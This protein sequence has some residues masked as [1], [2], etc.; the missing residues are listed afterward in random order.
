MALQCSLCIV[1]L[2]VI[3]P[4]GHLRSHESA[5]GVCE[6]LEL[7][8]PRPEKQSIDVARSS[9]VGRNN[10][11][12]ISPEHHSKVSHETI[13]KAFVNSSIADSTAYTSMRYVSDLD[14]DDSARTDLDEGKARRAAHT[15]DGDI[16]LV[17][18]YADT[19]DKDY[20]AARN[21]ECAK[22]EK[23]HPHICGK[24][25]QWSA[26]VDYGSLRLSLRSVLRYAKSF[27][28]NIYIITNGDHIPWLREASESGPIHVVNGNDLIAKA[29]GHVPNFNSHAF[30]LVMHRIPGLTE[31]FLQADDDVLFWKGAKKSSWFTEKG[32]IHHLAGTRWGEVYDL[33]VER[34]L[35][36]D[37]NVH[38][39]LCWS[40]HTF[41]PFRKKDMEKMW[42]QFNPQL[43]KTL[44]H[45]FRHPDDIDV[46]SFYPWFT[47]AQDAKANQ[48]KSNKYACGVALDCK[49][50]SGHDLGENYMSV[51]LQTPPGGCKDSDPLRSLRET[52]F[53]EPLPWEV[54]TAS[55]EHHVSPSNGTH[56]PVQLAHPKEAVVATAA[57]ATVP[58][59]SD[60]LNEVA[61]KGRSVPIAHR[62]GSTM[63]GFAE[64]SFEALRAT[65]KA[66][67]TFMELDVGLTKDGVVVVHHTDA[68]VGEGCHNTTFG[69]NILLHDITWPDLSKLRVG[70][71][72]I[73]SLLEVLQFAREKKLALQI[74]LKM[75]TNYA[76]AHECMA[77]PISHA[78][79]NRA[80]ADDPLARSV[81]RV[82]R[83][84]HFTDAVVSSFEAPRLLRF[85]T[86]V[87]A[88]HMPSFRTKL[89]LGGK[90]RLGE[91]E[92]TKI[93][94]LISQYN[95]SDV[96][97][98]V[99][100]A[101]REIIEKLR[102]KRIGTEIGMPSWG[103]CLH[104]KTGEQVMQA[105]TQ[106]QKE[107][108]DVVAMGADFICTDFPDEVSK[109][110]QAFGK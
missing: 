106:Q 87:R 46:T 100:Q 103:L 65:Y 102:A 70:G 76:L 93:L 28:R 90:K 45:P 36:K 72:R 86:Y 25:S 12:Q 95:I 2:F 15:L 78:C 11:S 21:R 85:S 108:S 33:P 3:H 69:A 107:L 17:Y 1:S 56:G 52:T 105:R 101:S 74:E 5:G 110:I 79:R 44:Q 60:F 92:Q 41:R 51:A 57:S 62:C 67:I 59:K 54:V 20:A 29:G 31:S 39:D 14:I 40:A 84:S 109:V 80:Q 50:G 9:Q 58:G 13:S 61:L 49:V 42:Q 55:R 98:Y 47:K 37:L 35:I 104:E 83:E 89:V 19:S 7:A 4:L 73:P 64:N 43:S 97:M 48:I 75:G 71:S 77:E 99:N 22:F 32:I 34:A 53:L 68:R 81:V 88:E 16:D 82:L 26:T 18:L 24:T 96:S 38:G 23:L 30:Y 94:S 8:A 6:R 66:G 27:I 91:A 10:I 63:T